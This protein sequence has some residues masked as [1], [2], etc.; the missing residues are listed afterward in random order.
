MKENGYKLY[1]ANAAFLDGRYDEAA[2]E[3]QNGTRAEDPYAA[4]NLAYMYR[5]GLGV[6]TDYGLAVSLY[7]SAHYLDA[8]VAAFNLALCYMRGLGV[9]TDLKRALFYMEK[10]AAQGCIDAQLYLGL[11]YLL[12]CV[13]DP[14]HIRAIH[15]IPSYHVVYNRTDMLLEGTADGTLEDT[16]WEVL[17]PDPERSAYMYRQG[18]QGH[19]VDEFPQ[20]IGDARYMLGQSL[21]EGVGGAPRPR[22]GF[23]HIEAAALGSGH[24]EARQFLCENAELAEHYGVNM[25][26]VR[27]LLGGRADAHTQ[28]R[29]NLQAPK[30]KQ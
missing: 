15:Y 22:A 7:E 1:R 2:L 3:Y 30:K 13:Y 4:V 5:E 12:G 27:G 14:V 29:M 25:E 20:Q 18:V 28:G 11:A 16:R 9:Q 8:G 17:A 24:E 10:S 6:P 26:R 19:D 23:R 21:I